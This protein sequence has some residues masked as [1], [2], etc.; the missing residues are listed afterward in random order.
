MPFGLTNAPAAFMDLM[1]RVCRPMLDRS[2]IVFI[3]DIL[4]YSR[5]EVDHAQ[6]LREVL[7]VLRKEKLYA[8][9]FKCAF[10]L[11]EVQ[12]LGH[13]INA[14]GILVNQAKVE[15]V[16]KWSL[17]KTP[18]EVRS[19]LGL[20]GYYR[21]LIQDF[22][23]IASPLMKLTRKEVKFI[24]GKEQEDAFKVLKEKLTQAPISVLPEGTDDMVV[25]CDA[26]YSGLGC[27]L[28]QR[29]NVIAYASRQL[30]T[31]EANYP[32]HDLELAAVVFALKIWRHYLYGVKCTI[33]TAKK[34]S[35]ISLIRKI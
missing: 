25:Y 34:A 30:K 31:H 12:F 2:V 27:V 11:R 20:A 15:A 24:W 33:Y 35:N 5:N 29:G 18:T 9:F 26:S 23:K 10:W 19:F 16:M 21:R 1:N 8:K 4:V 3:D 13:V 28:M 14:D 6:H 22:S 17:P 32:T 7:E